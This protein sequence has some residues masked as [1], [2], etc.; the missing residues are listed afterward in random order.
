MLLE[1]EEVVDLTLEDQEVYLLFLDLEHNYAEIQL[2]IIEELVEEASFMVAV[3]EQE[4]MRH[5]VKYLREEVEEVMQAM[6]EMVHMALLVVA[7]VDGTMDAG[8]A[9][10]LVTVEI[11]MVTEEEIMAQADKEEMNLII[12]KDIM[13]AMDLRQIYLALELEEAQKVAQEEEREDI[14]QGIVVEVLVII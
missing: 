12:M 3:E 1:R 5:L 14:T 2:M 13:A 8:T 11:L 9:L 6:E 10:I 4:V 7:V